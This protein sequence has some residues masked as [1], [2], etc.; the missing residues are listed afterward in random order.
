M[1]GKLWYL[2]AFL[3]AA[4]LEVSAQKDS[5]VLQK[6]IQRNTQF[7]TVN[8]LGELFLIDPRNQL[9]KIGTKGDS[10]GVFN[11]VTR[12]G[13]VTYIDAENPW[14]TILYYRGQSIVVVLDKYLNNVGSIDLRRLRMNSVTAVA[15]SYD[16]KVW[17]YDESAAKL[18]KLDDNGTVLLE[19]VDLRTVLSSVINPSVIKDDGNFVYLY[20]SE[21]GLFIFDHYG[22]FKRQLPLLHWKDISVSDKYIYGFDANRYFEYPLQSLNLKERALPLLFRSNV[23]IHLAANNIYLLKEGCIYV[24]RYL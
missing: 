5:L 7:F 22:T 15:S 18:K 4:S 17:V 24:Y 1:K 2:I 10:V 9:L 14:R 12:Y 20:D 11:E 21:K 19:T 23:Q 13:K 6:T 16:N 8:N 3:A